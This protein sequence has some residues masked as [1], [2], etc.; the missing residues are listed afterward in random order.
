MYRYILTRYCLQNGTVTL[1]PGAERI[2]EAA[3]E[4]VL[5]G[6]H[7][8]YRVRVRPG[9]IEGLEAFFRDAGLSANDVLTLSAAA[10]GRLHAEYR[11]APRQV[12][13]AAT[14]PV[15]A[16]APHSRPVRDE[17][18]SAHV[19]ARRSGSDSVALEAALAALCERSGLRLGRPGPGLWRLYAPLGERSYDVLIAEDAAAAQAPEFRVAAYPL[20]LLSEGQDL[21]R[22]EDAG[23]RGVA[24]TA[25]QDLAGLLRGGR[26]S[27]L[28]LERL[29]AGPGHLTGTEVSDALQGPALQERRLLEAAL[30]LLA[31]LPA[32]SL[33]SA[34]RLPGEGEAQRALIHSLSGAPLSLLDDLGGGELYL[35][36]DVASALRTAQTQLEDLRSRLPPRRAVAASSD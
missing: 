16:P 7:R 6:G 2:L 33:V 30:L 35:R 32:G 22:P 14:A 19:T 20:R 13:P 25:L 34:S 12:A 17:E 8:E 26:V 31:A 3:G 29:F 4:T 27:L 1:R 9:R 5:E 36:Q 24:L 21:S 18:L 11:H 15:P 28:Q 10:N 23:Q